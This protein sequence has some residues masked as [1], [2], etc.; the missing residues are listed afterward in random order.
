MI[1]TKIFMMMKPCFYE[2]NV[3]LK[4]MSS[5]SSSSFWRDPRYFIEAEG[6]YTHCCNDIRSPFKISMNYRWVL[7]NMKTNWYCC[8]AKLRTKF[9]TWQKSPFH[10]SNDLINIRLSCLMLFLNFD[11]LVWPCWFMYVNVTR[12]LPFATDFVW[13]FKSATVSFQNSWR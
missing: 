9:A 2:R 10:N 3:L 7:D 1:Y 11:R 6:H 8:S 13:W 5:S 12:W 4:I